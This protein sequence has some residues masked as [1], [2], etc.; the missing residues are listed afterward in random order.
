MG[1]INILICDDESDIVSALEIYLASEGYSVRKAYNGA[2]AV[3]C[4]KAHGDVSL[5]IMDVMMPVMDGIQAA[6]RIRETSNVPIIFL[7]AKSEDTDKILGLNI[8]GDDYITKPFNPVEV[9]ARVR[10]Q[11]RRYMTLGGTQKKEGTLS[12]GGIE[13][14]DGAKRV[15]VDG[16]EVTLT[17]TEYDILRHLMNNPGRVFSSKELYS[18]IW[19]EPGYGAEN[20]VAVHIR[21]IREKIEIDPAEPEYLKVVWG[22]GYKIERGAAK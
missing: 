20:T 16:N 21:H 3:E 6:S 1:N 19:G 9:V 10:S 14:D 7:S 8:G 13:L 17:P 5:V 2:Q 12:I 15:C 22:Q 11:L 4:V 18:S